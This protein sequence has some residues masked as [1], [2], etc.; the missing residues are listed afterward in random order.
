VAVVGLAK[1]LEE[2]WHP[3]TDFPVILPRD[4]DALYLVQRARDEAHRFALR[5]QKSKRTKM[6]TSTLNEL[7]GIGPKRVQSL[8]AY[9]GSPTAVRAATK[10]E[11]LKVPGIGDD[12]AQRILDSLNASETRG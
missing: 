6:L 10:D 2:L 12:T 1:R 8:I 3:N 7:E 9:F 4:S 5:Y 11:L